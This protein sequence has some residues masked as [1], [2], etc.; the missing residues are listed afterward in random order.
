MAKA[1]TKKT[2]Q[3]AETEQET[4]ETQKNCFIVTPIGDANSNTRRA[5]DGLIKSVIKP[6]MHE[7]GFVVHVAHEI[8]KPG[9]I[10]KQVIEHLLED[11]MVITN[12]TELN[13][14]VM[15][16]LAVR[17]AQ[18]KAVVSLAEKGTNLPFDISDERTIFYTNDMQGTED[19]KPQ[20]K[21]M[22]LA[23][24]EDE[25][26]DNPIYRAVTA[27]IMKEVVK[28][29]ADQYMIE[30]IDEL[31][32][33]II[34]NKPNN[35]TDRFEEK[36]RPLKPSTGFISISTSERKDADDFLKTIAKC[37]PVLAI[38]MRYVEDNIYEIIFDTEILKIPRRTIHQW[39]SISNL[40]ILNIIMNREDIEL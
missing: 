16:E 6:V 40:E 1:P 15:Y 28:E 14:N 27:S 21:T 8:S 20:L 36:F 13:P 24:L 35:K 23:A 2:E 17:H 5:I 4:T 25:E 26:P 39:L 31:K 34:N 33:L 37:I 30:Q 10:T 19:L 22:V 11:D 29:S 38:K 7:L 32:K 9:S 18:R 12:L 3:P